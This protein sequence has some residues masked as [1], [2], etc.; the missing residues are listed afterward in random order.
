MTAELW[1]AQV[2]QTRQS[3]ARLE[4]AM[5]D[6]IEQRRLTRTIVNGVD[7]GL[8]AIDAHGAYRLA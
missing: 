1:K 6:V 4:R 3:T 5:A 8:V 7:V 2:E